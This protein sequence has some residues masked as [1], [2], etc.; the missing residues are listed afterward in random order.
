MPAAEHAAAAPEKMAAVPEKIAP[1]AEAAAA[2]KPAEAMHAV[3]AEA[4]KPVAASEAPARM[5]EPQERSSAAEAPKPEA[6][7]A[8]PARRRLRRRQ[9]KPRRSASRPKAATVEAQRDSDGLRV[10]FSFAAPTPA[11]MFRRADTVW[12]VF[13]K[14][15]SIDVDAD[16]R[17]GRRHHRRRQPLPLDKGQAIRIRLN[18]PQMPSLAS[19]PRGGGNDWTLTFADRMQTPP[20]PLMVI[21]NITDPAL[22]NV[23]VPLAKP[24]QLHR[25]VDPDAGDTL[26]VVTAPPPVRGFI[27]RQDF[28]ELSLLESDPRRGGS[29]E[30]RRRHRRGRLRQGH[31]RPARRPDA[32]V[33]RRRAPSA[34]PP[35]CGRCSMSPSGARTRTKTFCRGSDALIK[36]AANAEPDQKTQARLDLARFYMARGMYQEATGVTNLIYSDTKPGSEEAA[37]LIVHAVASILIGHPEQALKDLANPAIGNNYDSQLWKGWP[38]RARANGRMRARNS[39][40]SNSRSPRCRSICSAS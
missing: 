21:R 7:K 16:P 10:T 28:V 17:Q 40:T 20:Q 2:T 6:S 5:A 31:A 11:A 34:R 25:L 8:E 36:A 15:G 1:P 32:V 13:D 3:A 26:L 39:R 24:G 18:R 27:K 9:R 4:A 23:T 38:L 35:R 29:S 14:A 33:G 19:D 30:F 12:L 22:A 37:V